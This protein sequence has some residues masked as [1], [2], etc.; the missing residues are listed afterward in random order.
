MNFLSRAFPLL[1]SDEDIR[2]SGSDSEEFE[3][4]ADEIANILENPD[5][6]AS[7][8]MAQNGYHILVMFLADLRL[9][10][11]CD[12]AMFQEDSRNII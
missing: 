8:G 10:M 2:L 3:E 9:K 7:L 1:D 12:K 4:R 11:F 5:M 6:H